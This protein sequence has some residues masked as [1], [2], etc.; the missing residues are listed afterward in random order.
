MRLNWMMDVRPKAVIFFACGALKSA[1]LSPKSAVD[2]S[3]KKSVSV[4]GP[5]GWSVGT[6]GRMPND[7]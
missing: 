3:R 6:L 2:K 1:T 5:S 4:P 7:F